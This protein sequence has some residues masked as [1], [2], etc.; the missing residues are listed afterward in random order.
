ML[1]ETIILVQIL[2][3]DVVMAADNAIIIAMI[4]ANFAPKHRNQIIMWGVLGAL[5]FRIIFAFFASYLFGFAYIK[6]I[7]GLLL[8]WI[9]N[10]LRRDLFNLKKIKSPTK[11]SK[12]PSYIQSVYKVLFADITLSFDNVIAVVGAAKDKINLMLLG[13]FLSVVLIVTLARFFAEQIKK[14]QWIGYVG[15]LVILAVALQLIIG[16]LVDFGVLSIND[17]F[18]KFF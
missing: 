10:D 15:L 14:H 13:L 4:A 12:E 17:T 16:G 7:G 9:V 5:V 11:I 1:E 6:I 18:K 8:I 2:F 3:I